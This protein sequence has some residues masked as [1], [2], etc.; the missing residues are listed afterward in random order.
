MVHRQDF[1]RP[2]CKGLMSLKNTLFED[3]YCLEKKWRHDDIRVYKN[4]FFLSRCCNEQNDI[5]WKIRFDITPYSRINWNTR[6]LLTFGSLVCLTNRTFTILQYA[7][8]A[9]RNA[10]D[11]KNGI[12]QIKFVD[13]IGEGSEILQQPDVLLIESQAFFPSYFHTLKSLK[14]MHSEIV[15]AENSLPFGKQLLN[16]KHSVEQDKPDYFKSSSFVEGFDI[17]CLNSE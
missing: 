16:Q 5:T 10:G 3:P 12:F 6:K 7:T 1:I 2:L 8:V 13:D 9:D 11:L 4:I 17:R 15:N 14:S